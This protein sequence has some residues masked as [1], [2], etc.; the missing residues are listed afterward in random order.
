MSDNIFAYTAP[1]ADMP[2]YLSINREK[3]GNVGVTVRGVSGV[4]AYIEL[5][6]ELWKNLLRDGT[7]NMAAKMRADDKDKEPEPEP[8]RKTA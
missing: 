8:G 3:N 1:G 2:P 7:C 4:T 5:A 6:D